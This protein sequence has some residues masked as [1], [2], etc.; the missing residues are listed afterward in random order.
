MEASHWLP[1]V[2]ICLMGLALFIYAILDGYDLGVGILLPLK[3]DKQQQ[4]D[5]MIASIGP[6]WDAN[7]TWLVLAVGILLIAFPDA[8]NFILAEL[9][10]PATLMLL[11]IILRGVAFD[12]RTKATTGHRPL[13]D[14]SFKFGSLLMA[15]SQ[16]Y[17]LGQ[18]VMG[19]QHDT[20][21]VIFSIISALCVTAAY[22]FVGGGWL[23]M[24]TQ[25]ELQITAARLTRIAAWLTALGIFLVSAVNPLVSENVS[26]RWFTFPQFFVLFPIPLLCAGLFIYVDRYLAHFP[27]A[28]DF[29][30]WSPFSSAVTI[31]FLS[32]QGLAYS[33][34]PYVI[35]GKLDIWQAAS[36]EESLMFIFYGVI[37]VVPFI[38][39]YTAFSYRV[40]WG[41]AR[42]LEYY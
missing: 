28:N 41:K 20:G 27:H 32:F 40:F 6:F 18:Y 8:Y 13:W 36:S 38:L 25:G 30:C 24:K 14:R 34:Y 11:G 5:I 16:G 23:V 15:L 17:M 33:F 35:P 9:Y 21:S 26:D 31:F 39:L 12:F 22:A 7:E 29:A 42:K 2:F 19:F 10:I 1:V 37:V 3:E 4:R